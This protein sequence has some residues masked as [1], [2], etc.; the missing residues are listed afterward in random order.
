MM[1]E[2][3]HNVYAIR[4]V[5]EKLGFFKRKPYRGD[6]PGVYKVWER[7]YDPEIMQSWKMTAALIRE[8]RDDVAAGGA[9]FLVFYVPYRASIHEDV[10][11]SMKRRYGVTEKRWD[12]EKVGTQ[13]ESLCNDIGVDYINPTKKFQREA[14]RLKT[15]RERLYYYYDGHW[16]EKGHALAASVLNEHITNGSF[17]K[18]K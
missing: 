13:L 15:K 2:A 6:I 17:I 12:M 10:W 5:M 8:L 11:Q 3:F 18:R 7:V 1:S 16:N 4:N 9:R 14:A